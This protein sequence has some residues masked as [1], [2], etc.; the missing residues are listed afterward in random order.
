MG[1]CQQLYYS[2]VDV[3]DVYECYSPYANEYVGELWHLEV[4]S[5]YVYLTLCLSLGDCGMCWGCLNGAVNNFL[6][7][8]VYFRGLRISTPVSIIKGLYPEH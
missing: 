1:C 8:R 2:S 3:P 7:F 4:L 6:G 5:F